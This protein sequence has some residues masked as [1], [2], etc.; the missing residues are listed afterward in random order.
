MIDTSVVKRLAIQCFQFENTHDDEELES[1]TQA[2]IEDY[3]AGLEPVAYVDKNSA[4]QISMK[5]YYGD[6]FD[7]SKFVG[8]SLYALKETDK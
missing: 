3:K 1:F 8:S 6:Y 5:S 2:V 4:G 7:M